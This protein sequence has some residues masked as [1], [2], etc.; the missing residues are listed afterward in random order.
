MSSNSIRSLKLILNTTLIFS[1]FIWC[2]FI[3]ATFYLLFIGDL[4]YPMDNISFLFPLDTK[5]AT[6]S[7]LVYS[8]FLYGFIVWIIH[9]L[10]RIVQSLEK[11]IL[12]TRFQIAGFNLI[13]QLIVWITVLKA[14]AEFILKIIFNSRLEIGISFSY[15]W[16]YIA[17]GS[18]F[19][20]LGKIFER[21]KIIR[22]ENDLTV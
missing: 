5:A 13:G 6:A 17:L 10:R 16:L 3:G 18:F 12:F 4:N 21:A 1:I 2:G 9:L 11:G 15:F 7:M 22:E 20:V 14:V 8:I 19:I